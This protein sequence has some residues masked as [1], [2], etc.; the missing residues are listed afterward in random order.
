MSD[1]ASVL[2]VSDVFLFLWLGK[3]LGQLTKALHE[4]SQQLLTAI[5]SSRQ[6]KGHV[7]DVTINYVASWLES[8]AGAELATYF[9]L[10]VAASGFHI[11]PQRAIAQRDRIHEQ[12]LQVA[13]EHHYTIVT[14]FPSHY[15]SGI[16]SIQTVDDVLEQIS[17]EPAQPATTVPYLTAH[18]STTHQTL[19]KPHV[20]GTIAGVIQSLLGNRPLPTEALILLLSYFSAEVLDELGLMSWAMLPGSLTAP[21]SLAPLDGNLLPDPTAPD[22]PKTFPQPLVNPDEPS[23]NAIAL[24]H[25]PSGD[26]MARLPDTPPS[27]VKHIANLTQHKTTQRGINQDIEDAIAADGL[28]DARDHESLNTNVNRDGKSW[29]RPAHAPIDTPD[30][31]FAPGKPGVADTL[32]PGPSGVPPAVDDGETPSPTLSPPREVEPPLPEHNAPEP[33][34]VSPPEEPAPP[35]SPSPDGF[36]EPVPLPSPPH[37][38]PGSSTPPPI[39]TPSPIVGSPVVPVPTPTIYSGDGGNRTFTIAAGSGETIITAF[40]GVGDGTSPP[41]AVRREIDLL[42]FGQGLTAETMVLTQ[43]GTDVLIQFENV[44][45]TIVVLKNFTLEWLDNLPQTTR[46]IESI[47]NIRFDNRV[48][49]SDSFDVINQTKMLRRNVVTFLDEGNNTKSGYDNSQDVING[50]AGNDYLEGRGGNDILRGGA[51]DDVLL[52]GT[53]DDRLVGGEGNDLLIGGDG[54]DTLEGGLGRD[55]FVIGRNQG[56]AIIQDFQLGDDWLQ[57]AEGLLPSQIAFVQEGQ[58]VHLVVDQSTIAIVKTLQ[59]ITALTTAFWPSPWS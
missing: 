4:K 5:Q 9:R 42:Q 3:T 57:L 25:N 6:F 35:P 44:N 13:L 21:A 45:D 37:E 7:A 39:S 56:T 17:L 31:P 48:T 19:H 27:P 55:R 40:G 10:D 33:N 47:G 12:E 46:D 50:Q 32:S 2:L 8:T 41:A 51:G 30:T 23:H 58:H 29:A 22:A 14:H 49:T 11:L 52:G 59:D 53:G 15:G 43:A 36:P 26:R 34:P 24:A 54:I 18:S 28:G 20:P 38:E 16:F 1:V